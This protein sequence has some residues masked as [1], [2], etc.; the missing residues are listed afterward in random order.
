MESIKQLYK[1]GKGPSGNRPPGPRKKH[2]GE[3]HE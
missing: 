1:I 3:N 2:K